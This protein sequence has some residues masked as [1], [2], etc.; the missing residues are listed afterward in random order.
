MAM[1]RLAFLRSSF[2]LDFASR[3]SSAICNRF[4]SAALR[5]DG[6]KDMDDAPPLDDLKMGGEH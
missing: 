6:E 4:R 2:S 5:G 1:E 3:S